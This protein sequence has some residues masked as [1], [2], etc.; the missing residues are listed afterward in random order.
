AARKPFSA[1]LRRLSA[2]RPWRLLGRERRLHAREKEKRDGEADPDDEAEE[3]QQVHGR[4]PAD[5]LLPKLAEIGHDADR[6]ERHDEENS[7][8]GIGFAHRRAHLGE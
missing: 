6:E 1:A 5:S 2:V 7:P 4:E 8:E 3:T